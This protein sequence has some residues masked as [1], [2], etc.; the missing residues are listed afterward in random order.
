MFHGFFGVFQVFSLPASPRP[1]GPTSRP[2]VWHD[3]PPP[4]R[5]HRQSPSDSKSLP[6]K[7]R[8]LPQ[9]FFQ[10]HVLLGCL[11][12]RKFVC[13]CM[14]IFPNSFS[15]GVFANLGFGA[16]PGRL[17]NHGFR[18]GSGAGSGTGSGAGS[19]QCF[20]EVPGRFPGI[21]SGTGFVM[22]EVRVPGRFTA[23]FQGGS[24]WVLGGSMART[25]WKRSG[26]GPGVL[27]GSVGEPVA[28][29]L[30]PALVLVWVVVVTD[31][32]CNPVRT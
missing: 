24:V 26:W 31:D 17:P 3:L 32:R 22:R 21:V 23:R 5:C 1:F 10:K 29:A 8:R 15:Y 13:V 2:C 16:V 25:Y 7:A 11:G 28:V 6:W 27:D 30:V 9:L 20:K 14:Y 19:G 18:E 4:S 12:S